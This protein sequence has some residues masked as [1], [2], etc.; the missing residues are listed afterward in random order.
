[1][2][3]DSSQTDPELSKLDQ[4]L[5][6][7]FQEEQHD[8]AEV[9]VWEHLSA[10]V[11]GR[12]PARPRSSTPTLLGLAGVTAA[13][14]VVLAV[15]LGVRAGVIHLGPKPATTPTPPAKA[16]QV[17]A[18]SIGLDL[19]PRGSVLL[20]WSSGSG[21]V[22][23]GSKLTG[24]TPASQQQL[25]FYQRSC[26]TPGQPV[27]MLTGQATAN[28]SLAL[29][30]HSMSV[31]VGLASVRSVVIRETPVDNGFARV[32]ADFGPPHT[33][34]SGG[35][36]A[37]AILP[38]GDAKPV[39]T[40]NLALF[41]DNSMSMQWTATRLDGKGPYTAQLHDGYC[42][43]GGSPLGKPASI[44]NSIGQAKIN[45]RWA[46][47]PD[48][49]THFLAAPSF[50]AIYSGQ[51]LVACGDI[52]LP[53]SPP[54][55]PVPGLP[56]GG[57]S[58]AATPSAPPARSSAALAFDGATQ[59]MILFG[60]TMTCQSTC[61]AG[62]GLFGDTWSW[63]GKTWIQRQPRQSPS[64]RSNAAIAY[65]AGHHVVVLFGGSGTGYGTG[66]G[67]T[68]I[69][70]GQNWLKEYPAISPP[71]RIGASMAY[72]AATQQV[73]LFGGYARSLGYPGTL[74]D[75]WAWNGTT[76]TQ[77][78]PVSSAP[79][80]SDAGLAYDEARG[81]LVLFGGSPSPANFLGDTWTWDGR[82]WTQQTTTGPNAKSGAAM[83]YDA[84]TKTVILVGGNG[85]TMGCVGMDHEMWWWDGASW[86]QLAPAVSAPAGF[87]ASM[88]F[89]A[90]RHELVL[91]GGQAAD[92]SFADTWTWSG[93][94]VRP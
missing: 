58:Q 49:A 88:V 84:D 23:V 14:A 20:D 76:W 65:D 64:P 5:Q 71:A 44:P 52:P 13:G 11:A 15:T 78:R 53:V 81:Q 86:T 87:N 32:C 10:R 39:A 59:Q 74:D 34:G 89:D 75:T 31:G 63:D 8:S 85:C 41:S 45:V 26:D 7:A 70:N 72:D 54:P 2:N 28:G 37:V 30:N 66:L 80:R 62:P 51:H 94:I 4:Q 46:P 6:A 17:S 36:E 18:I 79:A 42:A 82:N 24:L 33:I 12:T 83:A 29:Q 3:Q 73:I 35:Q 60:G 43:L 57:W 68:W 9:R 77:L 55:T 1:M 69:W 50:L 61:P 19:M 92:R 47:I 22:T 67:D 56:V 21:T 25:I 90:I 16:V 91:F 27:G 48:F 38:T 93:S 40:A